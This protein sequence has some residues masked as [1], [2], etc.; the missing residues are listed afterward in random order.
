MQRTTIGIRFH[1]CLYKQLTII[2]NYQHIREVPSRHMQ[3]DFYI[4]FQRF[5][6]KS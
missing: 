2:S 6:L 5:T 1:T 4:I 3:R